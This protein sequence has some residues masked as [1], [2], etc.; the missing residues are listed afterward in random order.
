MARILI[1]IG[2]HLCMAPRPQKE[3]ATLAAAGH[4]VTVCGVWFNA[5]LAERDRTLLHQQT[6]QFEPALDFRPH[7]SKL[8]RWGVRL[9]ARLAK[10]AFWHLG[11]FTPALMGYGAQALLNKA[12]QFKADLTIVHSEAGLWVAQQLIKSGYRVGVDFEDWFSQDLLPEVQKTR[13]VQHIAHLEQFLLAQCT[14]KVTT[15]QAMATALSKHYGTS[16]PQVIYN[17]F[18]RKD[19]VEPKPQ[20]SSILL[21]LHWFS[22]TIGPGRGLETLFSALPMVN[23][24]VEIHLRGNYPSNSQTWMKPLIPES[25]RSQI[26]IHPIVSNAELPQR[27]AEYDIGLALEMP[28]CKSRQYTITNKLFQYLQ[29]GLATIASNT[30]GQREILS[31]VPKA[32]T[33]IPCDDISALATAINQYGTDR[34]H[35]QHSKQAAYMAGQQIFCYDNQASKLLNTL[36]QALQQKF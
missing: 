21:K 1:L 34:H 32:G 31:Q 17:T 9:K 4:E 6:Y 11:I 16:T 12:K 14:Y 8:K 23:V 15:S 24:P 13:P 19:S 30:A 10:E 20:N 27:I 22:Q 5:G 2:A 25:W 33:L 28:Y 36:N 35:L 29:A 7:Q 26:F 3:A 18:P